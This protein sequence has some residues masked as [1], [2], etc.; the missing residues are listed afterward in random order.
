MSGWGRLA[1]G[2]GIHG[3]LRLHGPTL[4]W[5]GAR[6]HG[7]N[8][9]ELRGVYHALWLPQDNAQPGS[10][11]LNLEVADQMQHQACQNVL[12]TGFRDQRRL[13]CQREMGARP[14]VKPME[15]DGGLLLWE[16]LGS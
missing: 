16:I 5:L 3:L 6:Q 8:S 4:H 2:L 11:L 14:L 9:A 12:Q 7:D 15:R 13:R 1:L 10:K